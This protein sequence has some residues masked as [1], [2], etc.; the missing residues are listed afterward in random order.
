MLLYHPHDPARVECQ[1]EGRT[2][3]MLRP[4]DV[5]VNCRVR[6]RQETV[7]LEVEPRPISGGK[8]SFAGHKE[9]LA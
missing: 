9:N 7:Q 5:H 4:V 2:H 6:R 3:G 1:R 8:L